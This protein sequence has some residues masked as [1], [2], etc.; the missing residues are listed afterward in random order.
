[1]HK[2]LVLKFEPTF[3]PG[4]R[5][6][7]PTGRLGTVLESELNLPCHTLVEF[8]EVKPKGKNGVLKPSVRYQMFSDILKRCDNDN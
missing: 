5:V 8:D 2:Q 1:M 6:I 3:K 7:S 4:T